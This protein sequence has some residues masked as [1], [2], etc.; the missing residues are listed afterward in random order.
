MGP[1]SLKEYRQNSRKLGLSPSEVGSKLL[2]K[3]TYA[4]ILR[5]PKRFRTPISYPHPAGERIWV[6]LRDEI[7]PSSARRKK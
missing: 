7:L 4:W 5:N 2:Y 6:K 1:L 3:P